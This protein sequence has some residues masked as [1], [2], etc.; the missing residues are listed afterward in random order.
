MAGPLFYSVQARATL[1]L[2]LLASEIHSFMQAPTI[3]GG[4]GEIIES[5]ANA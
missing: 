5:P 1:L 2:P 3:G 4:G